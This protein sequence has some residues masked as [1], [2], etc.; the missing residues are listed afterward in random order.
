MRIGLIF[1]TLPLALFANM[2]E[3]HVVHGHAEFQQI[4]PTRLEIT[5]HDATIIDCK[6]FNIPDNHTVKI[7]QPNAKSRM[8]TRV[9]GH[10]PSQILGRLESVG[11]VFLINPNGIVFGPNSIVNTGSLIASTLDISNENF[12][13]EHYRFQLS[14]GAKGSKIINHGTLAAGVEG[15]IVLIAPHIINDGVINAKA[16][17]V[18]LLGSPVVTIDLT[19]DRLISFAVE[20][21]LEQ[22]IMQ[23]LGKINADEGD[24]FIRLSAAKHVIDN[25][26]NKDGMLEGKGIINDNGALRIASHSEILARN[27]SLHANAVEI[28]GKIDSQILDVNAQKTYVRTD[29]NAG[30]S[31]LFKGE[32]VIDMSSVTLLAG[33]KK[34]INFQ[35]ALILQ[36]KLTISAPGGTV[37]FSKVHGKGLTPLDVTANLIEVNQP[38]GITSSVTFN[39]K[40]YLASDITASRSNITFNG[41]TLVGGNQSV[42]LNTSW[43]KGDVRFNGPVD[44]QGACPTLTIRTGDGSV[45][46][47]ALIGKGSPLDDLSITAKAIQLSGVGGAASG[48][49]NKIIAD[50]GAINMKGEVYNAGEQSWKGDHFYID[51]SMQFISHG[52]PIEFARGVIQLK[53]D[54]ALQVNTQG[55]AFGFFEI[56]APKKADIS[57]VTSALS[58]GEIF[59]PDS[60]LSVQAKNVAIRGNVSASSINID[61]VGDI[62]NEL[63]PHN[64]FSKGDVYLNSKEG[65]TGYLDKNTL[66]IDSKQKI[67][68]GS[69]KI[70]NLKGES[71]D[72]IVHP[73]SGNHPELLIFNDREIYQY[74]GESFEDLEDLFSSLAPHLSSKKRGDYIDTSIVNPAPPLLYYKP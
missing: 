25:I 44:G 29:I 28:A 22:G 1:F 26:V 8:L 35:D 48:V 60:S 10:D 32:T 2:E 19:G 18:A 68:A 50:A 5:T 16:G 63:T 14:P 58:L 73:I 56:Q 13:K 7:V 65:S 17:R 38:I 34:G 23:Q 20:G 11:K 24:V 27:V 71:I 4:S 47:Q 21:E 41:P 39:G 57:L 49:K 74:E 59:A 12:K 52:K 55:G 37:S 36:K 45:I 67:Y 46:F 61:A 42:E 64:F 66:Y 62:I 31:I 70:V 69:P 30:D 40:I 33:G 51:N 3:P 15:S 53:E 72:N 6:S 54:A 43:G 9:K